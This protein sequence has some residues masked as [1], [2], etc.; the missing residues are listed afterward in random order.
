MRCSNW[1]EVTEKYQ[2]DDTALYIS[3]EPVDFIEY[4]YRFT[5]SI[6]LSVIEVYWYAIIAQ[7]RCDHKKYH[8]IYLCL[9]RNLGLFA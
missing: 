1:L 5:F 2:M 9:H 7:F 3:N 8:L 4:H 6:F